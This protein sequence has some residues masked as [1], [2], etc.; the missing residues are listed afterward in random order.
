MLSVFPGLLD[1]GILALVVLRFFVGAHLLRHAF[2]LYMHRNTVPARKH[3]VLAEVLLLKISGVLIIIGLFTQIAVLAALLGLAGDYI[4]KKKKGATPDAWFTALIALVLL[5]LL[6]NG[7][8]PF[9]F[10]LPL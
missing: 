9:A 1:Y 5:T 8:G 4:Y 6:F 2:T 3:L 10:D 7:P